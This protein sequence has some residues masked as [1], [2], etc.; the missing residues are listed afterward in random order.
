VI[1]VSSHLTSSCG[2]GKLESNTW[3]AV[4]KVVDIEPIITR[5]LS[6]EICRLF[7]EVQFIDEYQVFGVSIDFGVDQ[8]TLVTLM[9]TSAPVE[10]S[11]E[12]REIVFELDYGE[13]PFALIEGTYSRG[14]KLG[15]SFRSNCKRHVLGIECASVFVINYESICAIA[16]EH[17]QS[18]RIP[19]DVWKHKTMQVEFP[20]GSPPYVMLAGPRTFVVGK[21]GPGERWIKSFDLTP[22]A[23]RL[24]EQSD[25]SSEA[26][27]EVRCVTRTHVPESWCR[28]GFSV[29]Q[30]NFLVSEVS[31]RPNYSWK[32]RFNSS[33]CL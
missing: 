2:T 29:S 14:A 22:G 4:S 23:C 10:D 28:V 20:A 19:W 1:A 15:S 9:D 16:S 33:V 17:K 26:A 25:P 7:I 6:Q 24:V 30:D 12:P 11:Y 3:S 18:S 13:K 21:G 5:S 31:L 8:P 32:H 27:P